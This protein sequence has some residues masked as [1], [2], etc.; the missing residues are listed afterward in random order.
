MW[1]SDSSKSFLFC[2]GSQKKKTLVTRATF[3]HCG[4][5]GVSPAL[6]SYV[7]YHANAI[8]KKQTDLL[9]VMA[10]CDISMDRSIHQWDRLACKWAHSKCQLGRLFEESLALNCCL[11]ICSNNNSVNKNNNNNSS[12][13]NNNNY[14]WLFVLTKQQQQ[15]LVNVVDLTYWLGL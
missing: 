14:C 15:N 2:D 9:C 3:V 5:S 8:G 7:A 10:G 6:L 11:I 12:S 4:W 13:N 1:H